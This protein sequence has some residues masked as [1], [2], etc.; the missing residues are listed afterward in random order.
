MKLFIESVSNMNPFEKF[1]IKLFG[2]WLPHFTQWWLWVSTNIKRIFFFSIPINLSGRVLNLN[3]VKF[4]IDVSFLNYS[5]V[6]LFFF[7][8]IIIL[9]ADLNIEGQ[10]IQRISLDFAK[11]LHCCVLAWNVHSVTIFVIVGREARIS[12][13]GL[14]LRLLRTFRFIINYFC[15]WRRIYWRMYF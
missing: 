4:K 3:W 5:F 9:E 12:D 6:M 2:R 7:R 10:R 8:D 1:L 13:A 15:I 14:L 11:W